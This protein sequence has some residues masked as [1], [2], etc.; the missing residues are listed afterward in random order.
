MPRAPL[1]KNCFIL[2]FTADSYHWG[3]FGTSM[4]IYE[5]LL[6]RGYYVNYRPVEDTH[7]PLVNVPT[8][9][10]DFDSE[11]VARKFI[12]SNTQIVRAIKQA[13]LVLCNGEG[14]MHHHNTGPWQLLYL[15]YFAKKYV[16]KRV[17]LVNH[18]S[19]PSGSLEAS[20]QVDQLY[21]EVLRHLDYVA[22]R[23]IYSTQVLNRIGVKATQSF[24][25][26][27]RYINRHGFKRGLV[28]DGPIVVSGGVSL[29][30]EQANEIG[31]AIKPLIQKGGK[32]FYLAGAK[33]SPAGEDR[34]HFK[35][36]KNKIPSLQLFDAE[37]ID[38]WLGMIASASL[39]VSARFHH[40]IA[41][42]SLLTPV[43]CM[44]S[45]SP[46]VDGVCEMLKLDSPI[47]P[48][49]KAFRQTIRRAARERLGNANKTITEDT[50]KMMLTLGEVNFAEI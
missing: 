4:E 21:S 19:Y 26:L 50:W 10:V 16:N 22:S 32:A 44:P 30:Q 13:D 49:E 34:E 17:F 14:T 20:S 3:C 33:N 29:T 12:Q 18:S 11:S 42:A 47:K 43:V 2:N 39:L 45:N 24:D 41:A 23:E 38:E 35:I 31:A 25:C 40:T 48:S 9:L 28:S 36:M 5:S 27:P 37:T 46:K 1:R 7:T 6:E 8:T 15:M